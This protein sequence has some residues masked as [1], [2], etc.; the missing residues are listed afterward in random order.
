MEELLRFKNERYRS[1]LAS[2]TSDDVL[3]GAR[4]I[5]AALREQRVPTAIVSASR[6]APLILERVGL[7]DAV[8][9]LVDGSD[10]SR[11]KPDPEGYRLAAA[12]LGVDPAR[13][14]VVEDAPAGVLAARR[15]GAAV[16]AVGD[17]DLHPDV[18]CVVAGLEEVTLDDLR[19]LVGAPRE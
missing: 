14:L 17:R 2:V 3:G 19:A 4:E 1:S 9:V 5:L 7:R 18:A 6:N 12:R 11:T 13:C 16:L 8:D 10:T 15:A